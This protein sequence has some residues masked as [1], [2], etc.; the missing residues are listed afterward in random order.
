MTV[1]ESPLPFSTQELRTTTSRRSRERCRGGDRGLR[2]SPD[3]SDDCIEYRYPQTGMKGRDQAEIAATKNASHLGVPIFVVAASPTSA[4]LRRVR[5]GWVANWDDRAAHFLVVFG[6][7]PPG[8]S[9]SPDGE[10]PFSVHEAQPR[11]LGLAS[12]RS[13][14]TRFHF[15]VI[16]RYG[17]ACAL[18]KIDVREVLDT[19]SPGHRGVAPQQ[20]ASHQ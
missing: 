20:A 19:P 6:E 4:S 18:C 10:A 8:V 15:R 14:Q 16:L 11:R 5:L 7:Q 2:R 13:G 17:L 3:L 1:L 12:L 9:V